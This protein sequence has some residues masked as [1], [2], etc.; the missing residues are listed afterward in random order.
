LKHGGL[1]AI[2]W[3]FLALLAVIISAVVALTVIPRTL[4]AQVTMEV[5]QQADG[6]VFGKETQLDIFQDPKLKGQKLVHPFSEGSYTFAVHN[7]SNSA[8]LP[9]S[10]EITGANP[11]DIPLV[12]DL[13]KNGEYI[14]GGEG[15]ENMVPFS[16]LNFPELLLEGKRTDLYTIHWKWKTTSDE[17][18]TAIGNIGTQ[19]YT[20]LIQATGS[21]A[22]TRVTGPNTG[23]NTQ[24]FVWFALAL[25]SAV[26]ILLLLFFKKRKDDKADENPESFENR[27]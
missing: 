8:A 2:P 6:K 22:E 14:H 20:L 24:I 19:T 21:I 4:A 1:A 13:K 9:Y 26:L 18:D 3:L 12:F 5:Y 7:S 25:V 17:I 10:L 11:E 16:E 15:F 27:I 23:D